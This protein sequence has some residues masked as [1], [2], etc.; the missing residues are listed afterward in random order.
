VRTSLTIIN[1]KY[2][3]SVQVSQNEIPQI[4]HNPNCYRSKSPRRE[5]RGK[6]RP[7]QPK[8]SLNRVPRP[9]RARRGPRSALEDNA[10]ANQEHGQHCPPMCVYTRLPRYIIWR[11]MLTA[12]PCDVGWKRTQAPQRIP[13]PSKPSSRLPHCC[14]NACRLL[15]VTLARNSG[16][17]VRWTPRGIAGAPR[18]SL[19][20]GL[21]WS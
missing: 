4:F 2:H 13:T 19:E 10:P 18:R 6:S 5:R 16:H 14:C 21:C 9:R 20:T 17:R 11:S 3:C 12:C 8:S 1:T 7:Q 15:T